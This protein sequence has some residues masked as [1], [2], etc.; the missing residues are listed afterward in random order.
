MY[1]V[2]HTSYLNE[3]Q[4]KTDKDVMVLGHMAIIPFPVLCKCRKVLKRT[5]TT[6]I[7]CKD[8]E[9]GAEL[10]QN[11]NIA[12]G[13]VGQQL[14]PSLFLTYFW[15]IIDRKFFL[16]WWDEDLLLMIPDYI[17]FSALLYCDRVPSWESVNEFIN[18]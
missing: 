2:F 12:G 10:C 16:A 14:S 7:N 17:L 11:K 9:T 3:G 4:C 13:D 15:W 6:K 8:D 1:E 5:K 18:Y